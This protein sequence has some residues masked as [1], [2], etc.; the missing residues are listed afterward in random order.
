M[1]I[2][3]K[4]KH[5]PDRALAEEK[6]L[7]PGEVWSAMAWFRRAADVCDAGSAPGRWAHG[8]A[9]FG[10]SV[11]RPTPTAL[12]ARGAVRT[13]TMAIAEAIAVQAT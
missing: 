9:R 2:D 3:K 11:Q 12:A 13:A 4:A 7:R 8:F 1:A 10:G 5:R 6:G